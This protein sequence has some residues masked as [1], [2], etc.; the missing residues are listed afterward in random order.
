MD[1]V[2]KLYDLLLD[3]K[4]QYDQNSE[5]T[6]LM[7]IQ[8]Y[9]IQAYTNVTNAKWQEANKQLTQAEKDYL[10]IMGEDIKKL[11]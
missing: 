4:K 6:K 9:V 5:K 1:D 8:N 11:K 3:Y 7:V 2:T 10:E